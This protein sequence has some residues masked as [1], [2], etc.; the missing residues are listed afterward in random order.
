MGHSQEGPEGPYC[1]PVKQLNKP[2][3]WAGIRV[4]PQGNSA[5]TYCEL[6]CGMGGFSHAATKMGGALQWACDISPSA[7][8]NFNLD[9]HGRQTT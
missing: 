7:T 2:G 1:F 3:Q 8:G 5:W 4:A 9:F 6:A